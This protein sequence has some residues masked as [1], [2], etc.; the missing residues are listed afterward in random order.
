MWFYVTDDDDED[1]DDE[2]VE[3]NEA[4]NELTELPQDIVISGEG[5]DS[6]ATEPSK[7]IHYMPTVH[8][9]SV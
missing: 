3:P 4:E 6:E 2:D 9:L 8:L 1:S 7:G 5:A